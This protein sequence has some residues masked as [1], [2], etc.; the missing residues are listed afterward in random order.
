MS[1]IWHYAAMRDV[2]PSQRIAFKVLESAVMDRDVQFAL[3]EDLDIWLVLA[4]GRKVNIEECRIRLLARMG[5]RRLENG[6]N[7]I[8]IDLKR[9]IEDLG[10]HFQQTYVGEYTYSCPVCGE[11]IAQT[12]QKCPVCET[13]VVWLHSRV[14][15][16]LYGSPAAAKRE[17][18]VILPQKPAETLALKQLGLRG[19]ANTAEQRRFQDAASLLSDDRIRGMV[20]Y[21][22]Q[23]HR[24]RAGLQHLINWMKKE[25]KGTRK[26]KRVLP[27]ELDL[28]SQI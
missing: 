27:A 1:S 12:D 14:W 15:R 23:E 28:S 10:V 13:P 5:I 25:A 17:L 9:V 24:G 2:T 22:A 7:F 20:R 8:E 4:T 26:S 18:S 3:S 11:S 21:V 16:D 6:V 19:F